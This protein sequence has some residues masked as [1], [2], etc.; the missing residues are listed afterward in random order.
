MSY[1]RKPVSSNINYFLDSGF[2]QRN[3]VKRSY[4]NLS[5]G[6]VLLFSTHFEEQSAPLMSFRR[7]G[8]TEK[9]LLNINAL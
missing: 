4:A 5:I 9:S 7:S 3:D 2:H 6:K 8:A 1:R